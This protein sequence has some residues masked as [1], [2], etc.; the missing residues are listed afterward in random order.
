[1]GIINPPTFSEKMSLGAIAGTIIPIAKAIITAKAITVD[2]LSVEN[3][4]LPKLK[5]SV[6][7]IMPS[8][9]KPIVIKKL[10]PTN[11]GW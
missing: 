6:I 8:K 11:Y 10:P 7:A 1:M 2:A 9:I 4:L 3:A 5:N